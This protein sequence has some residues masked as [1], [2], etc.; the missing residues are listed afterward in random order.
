MDI[1]EFAMNMELEG[2]T[3]YE[4][5]AATSSNPGIRR[6]LLEM[7]ED[8]AA[9]YELFKAMKE[10]QAWGGKSTKSKVLT[11]AKVFFE[12]LAEK[13]AAEF[14]KDELAVWEKLRAAE[15]RAEE[16]YRKQAVDASDEASR[17]AW[18]TIADEERKHHHLIDNM[19]EFLE[20]PT[21]WLENAEWHQMESY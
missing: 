10:G 2:K 15:Q 5:A 18:N 20:R 14:P 8:E 12:E 6:I 3:L 13:G 9:H 19:I 1:F 11:T 4:D 17:R 16:Y 7:A 21:R